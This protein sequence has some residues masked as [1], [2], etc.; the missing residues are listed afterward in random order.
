MLYSPSGILSK[1][2]SVVFVH[3]ALG[4]SVIL[5]SGLKPDLF[6]A[7]MWLFLP[8]IGQVCCIGSSAGFG[9]KKTY[10]L[11]SLSNDSLTPSEID[12]LMVTE[13]PPFCPV[14][15]HPVNRKKRKRTGI[16]FF[17]EEILLNIGQ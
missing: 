4:L 7:K 13:W 9:F 1:V 6:I 12:R 14:A 3:P 11:P 5:P 2:H 10:N 16:I 17:M 8:G 15:V